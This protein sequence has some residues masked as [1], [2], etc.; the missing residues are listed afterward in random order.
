MHLIMENPDLGC[1]RRPALPALTR[2]MIIIVAMHIA[3][4]PVDVDRQIVT[5]QG[6]NKLSPSAHKAFPLRANA[7]VKTT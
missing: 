2:D 6:S 5:L 7:F 4:C 3:I 1:F